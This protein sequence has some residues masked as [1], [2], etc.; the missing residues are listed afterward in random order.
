M[1]KK[2]QAEDLSALIRAG[3][4]PEETYDEPVETPEPEAAAP[5]LPVEP[6]KPAETA[7]APAGEPEKPAEEPEKPPHDGPYIPKTR[8]DEVNERRKAAEAKLRELEARAQA[9]DPAKAV[10]FDFKGKEK[11]YM[12]AVLDGNTDKALSIRD[13]IRLAE[14]ALF[15][16]MTQKAEQTARTA[17]KQDIKLEQTIAELTAQ[18]PVFDADHEGYDDDLTREALTFQRTFIS[19]G[20]DPDKAL[21]K[22]VAYV[23]KIHDLREAGAEPAPQGLQAAKAETPAPTQAQIDSKLRAANQQPPLNSTAGK[24]APRNL[25]IMQMSD[26]EFEALSPA[27]IR[28]LRGD[29]RPGA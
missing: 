19:E 27:D 26:E 9:A 11:E 17:A 20:Y 7:V 1:A 23:A 13:E 10:D 25:D 4:D 3:A 21:R 18:Y 22:A 29:F 5:E 12:D 8:F 6:E 15:Q 24:D 14:Q 16:Q 2:E 28:K